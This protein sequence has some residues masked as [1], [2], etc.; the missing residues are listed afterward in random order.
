MRTATEKRRAFR[1]LLAR[2]EVALAPSCGDPITC[3]LI[4]SLGLHA[5]HGSGSSLHRAA[6]FADAGILTMTEMVSVLA[7]MAESVEIPVI[8]DADTGFGGVVN[9][10][11]TVKEYERAGLAAMHIED[12]LT[13]KRP[14]SASS[15]LSTISLDEMVDKIKAAVDART[16]HEFVII[17]RSEAGDTSEVIDR[18]AACAEAGADAAW[19]SASTPEEISVTRAEID[20]PLVGVLPRAMSLGEYGALGANVACLPTWLE[21]VATIAKR[22]LLVEL[23][24]R[25][26]MTEYLA[27]LDGVDEARRFVQ[28]QGGAELR[29]IEARFSH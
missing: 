21:T 6:G 19:L 24:E 26:T 27:T 16:D 28:D 25:G 7:R 18:L 4:A 15:G 2:N 29:D 23:R 11:R 12:Q 10:V 20:R 9:V 8:G 17:A 13:P 22:Q 14:P 1:A 3:R 5:I